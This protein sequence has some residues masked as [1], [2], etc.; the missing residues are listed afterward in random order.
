[1]NDTGQLA[2]QPSGSA[3]DFETL[4]WSVSLRLMDLP[5]ERVEAEIL[6]AQRQL[7]RVLELDRSALWQTRP[8][9]PGKF[10][11]THVYTAEHDGLAAALTDG[12]L[13]GEAGREFRLFDFPIKRNADA[14]DHFAWVVQRT[15]DGLTTVIAD[16]DDLPA[17][18]AFDAETFRR[19]GTLSTVLVPLI[20][21]GAA[22][23]CLSFAT[24]RAVRRWEPALVVRFERLA[25]VFAKA[26]AKKRADERLQAALGE[27]QRLRD[28]LEHENIYLQGEIRERRNPAQIVG[29]L[30]WRFFQAARGGRT[31]AH[32]GDPHTDR[33]AHPRPARGRH[34]SGTAADHAREPDGPAGNRQARQAAPVVVETP[35][36]GMTHV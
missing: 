31:R 30:G 2:A 22:L 33:L 36:Y 6:D 25:Q 28:R 34:D 23:G 15:L 13:P 20:A 16:L 4:L 32:P 29:T 27:L 18:A 5:G 24:T 10:F 11:V 14:S 3:P 26:L 21:Q 1:M 12:S 35:K 19:F 7:C 8:E 9:A 17:E